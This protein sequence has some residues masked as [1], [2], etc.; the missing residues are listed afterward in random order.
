MLSNVKIST[1]FAL[2]AFI[3]LIGFLLLAGFELYGF[4][5]TLM[6]DRMDK[7]RNLVE[8]A[9]SNIAYYQSLEKDGLLTREEAQ[10]RAK[11][12]VKKLRYDEKEYFWINDLQPK[13]VMHPYKPQLDGKNLSNV[14]DQEGTYLF[15]EMVKV[16]KDGGAGFVNYMWPKPG[17]D[18]EQAFQ[19][20]SYVKEF[21]PWGWIIGSGIYVDDVQNVFL[22]K[23]FVSGIFILMIMGVIGALATIIVRSIATPLK[24]SIDQMRALAAEEDITVQ[25]LD[26]KDE[27]GEMALALQYFKEKNQEAKRLREEQEEQNE[28]EK[29]QKKI[30]ELTSEYESFSIKATQAVS[31]AAMELSNTAE[32]MINFADSTKNQSDS[33]ANAT[34]TTTE[35]VGSVASAT[36]ELSSSIKEISNQIDRNMTVVNDTVSSVEEADATSLR[37]TESATEIGDV[38]NLIRDIANQINLLSL[39]ATIESARAGEAGKG[40]AVVANEVKKLSMETSQATDKVEEQ[41][42]NIQKISGNVV[43]VLKS[44]AETVHSIKEYSGNV[45]IAIEEQEAVTSEISHNMLNTSKEVGQINENIKNIQSSSDNTKNSSTQVFE[46]AKQ[47]S[48][49]AEEI[50][51]KTELFL[52]SV[53]EA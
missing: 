1:K 21:G 51:E 28:K 15:N 39:N 37:L 42:S 34:G 26:R 40:F 35:N 18:K 53:R 46:A 41:I 45:A 22:N 47:L 43:D 11:E 7:T 19:K 10:E 31:D 44:I 48:K 2:F 52:K 17:A 9:H 6:Q 14:K 3:P 24:K 20:V 5:N 16:V 4:K 32:N 30:Q 50:Q 38:I 33:A 23:A 49:Q 29:R 13:M 36:E 25:G 12:A 27:I 8:V